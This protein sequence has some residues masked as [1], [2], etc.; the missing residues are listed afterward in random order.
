MK[1]K[2][3]PITLNYWLNFYTHQWDR[4]VETSPFVDEMKMISPEKDL[5]KFREMSESSYFKYREIA[6]IVDLVILNVDF[7]QHDPQALIFA[8]MY[9]IIG[10]EIG[11]FTGEEI[12]MDIP[13]SSVFLLA[14]REGFHKV[15]GAFI[16]QY[17]DAEL[18]DLLELIQRAAVYF[19]LTIDFNL[20]LAISKNKEKAMKVSICFLNS[21]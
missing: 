8:I 11:Q 1:W 7:L 10:R 5:I 13:N 15:F 3:N 21:S 6:Q 4:F 2:L 12:V 14:D 19:N 18:A 20:P 9:L 16:R 17:I